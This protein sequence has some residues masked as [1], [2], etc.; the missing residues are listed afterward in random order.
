M[1][2]EKYSLKTHL[3]TELKEKEKLTFNNIAKIQIHMEQMENKI[4]QQFINQKQFK[5]MKSNET[6]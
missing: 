5:L 6:Q 4:A 2:R 3:V 1:P